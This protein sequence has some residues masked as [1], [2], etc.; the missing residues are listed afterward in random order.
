D[1]SPDIP[2]DISFDAPASDWTLEAEGIRVDVYRDPFTYNVIN[3]LDLLSLG[4]LGRGSGDGY[5]SLA[6]TS[7]DLSWESL[8]SP[9]YYG[10]TADLETWRDDFVVAEAAEGDGTLDL[11]LVQRD[12][13]GPE[14]NVHMSVRPST[15][16][17]EAS[18]STGAPRA[19]AAAFE[20]NDDEA[21]LGFGERFNRTNQRGVDVYSWTEEGGVGTGEGDP[22]GPAN[23]APNGEAMTNYPVP[24]F[25]G[26]GDHGADGYGFWL[27]STWRS[28]FNLATDRDDAWRVWHIGPAIAFEVYTLIPDD[29][30]PWPYHLI[31]LFTET[32]GRP[33][34]PP[35][36]T[37]GPRRRINRGDMQG[38]VP[39]IQAMRDLDLAIT[40]VDDAMHFLP[41]GSHVGIE[42][43]LSD[44]ISSAETL[45][46]RVNAYYNSYL[47]TADDSQIRDTY[48]EG[49]A[50]D[51]F[52]LDSS[53]SPSEV[54]MISGGIVTVSMVDFSSPAAAT[55]YRSILQWALDV[56]YS[57]WMYD[58]GEYVQPDTV[59]ASGMTGEEFHNLY[60]VLYQQAAHDFLESGPH[61]GDWL[62]FVRSGYTGASQYSPMV[63]SGDP[64]ASFESSD[65]LPSM[66]RA[67][68]NMGISGVPH[69]GGDING[70]HC[71]AD[72]SEAAD[73][74]LLVRWIQQGA[75]T[76]NMQDQDAC[77]GGTGDK[78]N[79][80]DDAQAQQAWQTYA[81]LHTRLF[82]YLYTLSHLAHATGAPIIRHVFLEA[83]GLPH[84]GVDEAYFLGPAILVAPVVERGATTKTLDVPIGLYLDWAEEEIVTG[85]G[86]VTLDAPLDKLP[87]LLRDGYIVPLL[88]PT[89]DTLAAETHG[90]V[91]GPGDVSGVYDVVGFVSAAIGNASFTFHDGGELAVSWAGS[92]SPPTGFAEASTE[93]ELSTCDGCYLTQDLGGG[94]MRARISSSNT[95]VAAGGLTVTHSVGRTVRWDLYLLE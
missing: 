93:A 90:E 13:S 51:Y 38:G 81:R 12:G 65:G 16:R 82:P 78:A 4:S 18:L 19:W 77:L 44:W 74:E 7:G 41:R 62:T 83:P 89:I 86:S 26:T 67:G 71:T 24:F 47:S 9:G 68:V 64:A 88:D 31:D 30:R 35:G 2:G 15:F 57:G 25:I 8:I 55:W 29:P 66:I 45:G 60:P 76:P 61:A 56:G 85:G 58:F 14:V 40:A 52:L 37:L 91:V 87:L 32:T 21:F 73:E 92:F 33:M 5:G 11:V 42:T 70:F 94:L 54:W 10:F 63:W 1:V 84:V 53:G 46:Y 6:W 59:S 69:W 48:L 22:P 20:T 49:V 75:M 80:F 79:I 72:G 3:M 95:S 36:W 43:E 27:D 23:P 34:I 50:S 17:L 39:E 28:E